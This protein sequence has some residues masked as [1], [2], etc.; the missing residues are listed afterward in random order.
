MK[1][2]NILTIALVVIAGIYFAINAKKQMNKIENNYEVVKGDPLKARIYT[3][4]NG[5][6]VYLTS[7]SDAP[8]VQTNIAVRAGSKNDPAYATGLA[9][10]LEHMLFK[11]TDVFGSLDFEKEVLLLD[12]IEGLYEEYRSYEMSDNQNRDRIWRKIDSISGEAAKYAI[13]NEYDKMVTGL[14]AKGTNAYTSFEKTVYINDIP[15]NQIEK[16]LKLEAERFRYPVFRLFHTELEAVYEEKNRSLDSDG[17]KLFESLFDLLFPNH[18]YGQQTTIGTIEHLK[19]PSLTEIRK[20]F[21]KYYVP[22]N[23]AMC[24]SGDFDYDETIRLIDKYWGS[25]E[26]KEIP[27]FKVI[28]EQPLKEPVFSEVYGPE[29]ERLYIGFRFDGANT[30]DAT[31]LSMVD[32]VLSNSAAGL[33]DLNLNQAQRLIGGG[34]FPYVLKDYSI[35]GFYGS[36]KQGQSLE[37]VKDLL[38]S[39]IEEVKKGNFEDWLVEAIISDLKLNQIEKL[40]NNSGR[41]NEFVEAFILDMSWQDYQ[42][43][44]A[45]LEKITKQDIIDF[46]NTRYTDNY[47]VCYKR[48]GEDKSVMKVVKPD[49]TPVSVNREDQ[50]DFLVHLLSEDTKDIDPVFLDFDRDIQKSKIGDVPLFYKQNTENERFKLDYILD[51]G[52]DHDNRLELAVDYLKFLGTPDMTPSDKAKEF[53]KL[54]CSLSVKCSADKTQITLS[55]LANN[56]NESVQLFENILDN[57][58]VDDEALVELKATK[59]KER[60]DAK[61]NRQIILWRAMGNYAKY[62]V[63]SSFM[64]VLSEEELNNISS[65]ELLDLIHNL[66]SYNHRIVYY[67]PESI[68]KVVSELEILH[69]NKSTL[70]SIP[71]KKEFVENVIDKPIVYVVDYDMKQAE[72]MILS[73]GNKLNINEYSQ[74]KFHNEYFGGGMS[75]IVF[76]EIRE[77]QALAYSVYS[78]YTIPKD[79]NTSHYSMSYIGTQADKLAEAMKGMFQLLNTMPE[80]ES[81]MQNAKEAIEQKIR[82]ERLT[83]SKVLTEYEKANKLGLQHDIRKDLYESVQDFDMSSLRDFHN[84]HIA[85]G[86]RVVLVLGSKNNLDLDVLQ[87]Y[88]EIKHLTLEDVFGY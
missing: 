71:I 25:F 53:Y 65:T 49:I 17:S 55:G 79:T 39:Q 60:A 68:D 38:L 75:S 77:S 67:G 70:K 57:A 31:M 7:Y 78:T 46:A 52:K 2:K 41:A 74:I 37:E 86:T 27:S 80:A 58:V 48:N 34:C 4:D 69:L 42:N 88:G 73:K 51:M 26:R 28:Q 43:Q 44:M 85:N 20:Y 50:S 36:P 30:K 21:N 66:T 33:I 87:E 9:H 22:N 5:L 3:L 40:E 62:G 29:S 84:S 72:V 18:Q 35:H 16:W 59:L 23:M 12:E 13:A 83:K 54:G 11:G 63:N 64:N 47:V 24:L 1:S 32:M 76:Q 15:S 61:L 10:Y 81:N 8:R 6:K 14:G 45:E 82:T 56:F 19:N